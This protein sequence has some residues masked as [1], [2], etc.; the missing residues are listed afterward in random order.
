M[1][2][3]SS[4]SVTQESGLKELSV[5]EY[6]RLKSSFDAFD[7]DHTGSIEAEDFIYFMRCKYLYTDNSLWCYY[8]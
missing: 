6:K 4:C 2:R 7:P 8:E 5:E 3:Y 1:K